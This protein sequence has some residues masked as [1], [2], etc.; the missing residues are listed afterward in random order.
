MGSIYS[1]VEDS[2]NEILIP[3]SN[4]D[5]DAVIALKSTKRVIYPYFDRTDSF[6]FFIS[7]LY[8]VLYVIIQNYTKKRHYTVLFFLDVTYTRFLKFYILFESLKIRVN[9]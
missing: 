1:R 5:A 8:I 6:E 4:K 3:F 2:G 9:L 7:M